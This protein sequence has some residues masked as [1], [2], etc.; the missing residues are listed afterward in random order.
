MWNTVIAF[1]TVPG[2][3]LTFGERASIAGSVTLQGMLVIFAAL[4][5]LWGAVEIMHAL[6]H[7]K[8]KKT[9]EPQ[10]VAEASA[11]AQS[12]SNVVSVDDG[13]IVAA[14]IAAITAARTEEGNQSAFR[15]VSFQR[16]A[17]NAKKRF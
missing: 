2:E 14:I 10:Q 6:L 12:N 3:E 13:A 5:I 11:P 1:L 9:T 15:V 7:R 17:S 16:A 8:P 4:A